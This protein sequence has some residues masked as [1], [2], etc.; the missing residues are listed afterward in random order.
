MEET[1]FFKKIKHTYLRLDSSCLEDKELI[2]FLS[3]RKAQQNIFLKGR[4]SSIILLIV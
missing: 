2:S 1:P 4:D 3:T